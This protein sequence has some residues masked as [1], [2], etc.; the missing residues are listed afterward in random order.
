[1]LY[2]NNT[3]NLGV[4]MS[5]ASIALTEPNEAWITMMLERQEYSSKTELINDLIRRARHAEEHRQAVRAQL[6][7][8]EQSGMSERAPEDIRQMVKKRM[9][10]T[11]DV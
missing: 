10:S 6:I 11:G 9:R 7:E 4:H 5:R 3:P 8:A 1:M 2:T